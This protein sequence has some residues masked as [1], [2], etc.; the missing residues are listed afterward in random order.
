MIVPFY[1]ICIEYLYVVIFKNDEI[2]AQNFYL[3]SSFIFSF[4]VE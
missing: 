2:K 4:K 1:Q 3:N